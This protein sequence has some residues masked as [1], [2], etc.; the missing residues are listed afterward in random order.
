[1]N[2]LNWTLCKRS[3]RLVVTGVRSQSQSTTR[4]GNLHSLSIKE[5]CSLPFPSSFFKSDSK[6][7]ALLTPIKS[8]KYFG[9]FYVVLR[10][11]IAEWITPLDSYH[12]SDRNGHVDDPNRTPER[13]LWLM[14]GEVLQS[15]DWSAGSYK[16]SNEWVGQWRGFI[17]FCT[18]SHT[19]PV[20]IQPNGAVISKRLR[21]V[22]YPHWLIRSR[23]SVTT[24]D[25]LVIPKPK[26]SWDQVK[27]GITDW[28][29]QIRRS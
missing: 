20:L 9:Q 27:P 28:F 13:E 21:K 4:I 10:V 11:K 29:G 14:E 6:W 22:L 5:G 3:R 8:I 25:K 18:V 12:R 26:L 7:H 17:G 23:R 15:I 1:M 16:L 19:N 2:R 24:E